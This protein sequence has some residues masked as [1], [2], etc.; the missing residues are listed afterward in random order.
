MV[1]EDKEE[2]QIAQAEE[3]M[4]NLT[5]E[6]AETEIEPAEETVKE[7]APAEEQP[8]EEEAEEEAKPKKKKEE[9]EIVEERTYTVPLSRALVRPPKK[10]APRAMQLL[11]A[12]HNQTHE[13]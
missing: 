7:E 4:P 1:I 6:T 10:R 5:E 9:E 2:Q 3:E 12:L 13:A 8:E 11:K